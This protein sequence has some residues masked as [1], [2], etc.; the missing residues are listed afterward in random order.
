[1]VPLFVKRPRGKSYARAGVAFYC[2]EHGL[3]AKG[4]GKKTAFL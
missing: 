2:P 1:M 4:R 3:V